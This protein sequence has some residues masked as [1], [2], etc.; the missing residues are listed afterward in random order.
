MRPICKAELSNKT[1][2]STRATKFCFGYVA[3]IRYCGDV[4]GCQ[5]VACSPVLGPVRDGRQTVSSAATSKIRNGPVA[6]PVK[7]HHGVASG[8][9]TNSVDQV[10]RQDAVGQTYR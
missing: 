8:R 7:L 5:V 9:T 1:E 4:V 3:S 10:V 6:V 2:K